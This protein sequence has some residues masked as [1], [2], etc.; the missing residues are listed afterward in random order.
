MKTLLRLMSVIAL[1]T[2]IVAGPEAVSAGARG[3]LG[4][5]VAARL[6]EAAIVRKVSSSATRVLDWF[7]SEW[8]TRPL[9]PSFGVGLDLAQQALNQVG[10]DQL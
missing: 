7:G 5:E 3:Q 2:L 8:A 9:A 6:E 1:L 10:A 4:S